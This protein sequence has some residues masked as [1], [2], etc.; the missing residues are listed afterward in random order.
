MAG[1][2]D[3][4]DR[5]E[6]DAY[7]SIDMDTN[8]SHCLVSPRITRFAD[9]FKRKS[10]TGK[11]QSREMDQFGGCTPEYSSCRRSPRTLETLC[12]VAERTVRPGIDVV[13]SP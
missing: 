2:V 11:S 12:G 10:R 6:R 13:C 9:I 8:G 7:V 1:S 4:L 5:A 3:H